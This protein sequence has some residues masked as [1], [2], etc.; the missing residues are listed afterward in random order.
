[1]KCAH[2][3]KVCFKPLL[4]VLAHVDMTLLLLLTQ[5]ARHKF[6]A[7]LMHVQMVVQNT[8]N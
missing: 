5:Q 4:K 1:M 8:F 7:N 6:G 2:L 3:Q